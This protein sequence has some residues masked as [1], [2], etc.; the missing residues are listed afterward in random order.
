L[1]RW[2]YNGNH[3]SMPSVISVRDFMDQ[4]DTYYPKIYGFFYRDCRHRETAEDLTATTFTKALR[5]IKTSGN[6]IRNFNAWIYKIATNELFSYLTRQK[7]RR[8]LVV[9]DA[10][11]RLLDS[12]RD[13]R[14]ERDDFIDFWP[15]R[16]AVQKLKAE[17]RVLID[18]HF[19]EKMDYT[20]MAEIL[21]VKEVTLRSKIHRTL[22]K[23]QGILREVDR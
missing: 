19:F 21:K 5:Y 23:L 18:M 10:D 22:K 11:G 8:A 14:R 2:C 1:T 9:E 3:F 12:V 6:I 17:E 4:Y 20:E 15:V 16:Q 7:K 13:E